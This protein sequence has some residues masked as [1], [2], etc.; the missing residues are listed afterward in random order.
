MGTK[1]SILILV[2]ALSGDAP[3]KRAA[4]QAALKTYAGL[5]GEWKGTGQA[6]RGSAKGSWAESADWAW[7]LTNDS[8]ALKYA[9]DKGK[10]LRKGLLKPG[11]KR[12]EFLFEA[13]LPDDT[14]RT[15][16]GKTGARDILVLTPE[17]EVDDGLARITITPLHD[18]RL[19]IL[20]EAKD[21]S[22]GFTRLG[23]V[24]FTRKGV[25]FAAGDST[26]ACIVTE[27]RG[28]IEVKYKGKTY[29]VCCSGCKDLFKQDPEAVLAEAARRSKAK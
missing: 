27:G 11:P 12:G 13:T 19:L 5:V 25:A 16:V 10:Y 3:P 8:A 23:E 29:Y 9:S 2:A 14:K 21:P 4:D 6:Q 7:S 22:G 1:L 26:P 28:T 15:F 24:G 20:M 18:T 17:K